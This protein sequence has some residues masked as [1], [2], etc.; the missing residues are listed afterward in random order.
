MFVLFFS[1]TFFGQPLES[2]KDIIDYDEEYEIVESNLDELDSTDL[3]HFWIDNEVEQ[4]YGFIASNYS[5]LWIKFLSIIPN[6]DQPKQYFV[7]GKSMVSDNVCEFQGLIEIK[8]SYNVKT[9]EFP[10]RKTGILAGE[11]VFYEDAES[12]HSGIFRGRFVTYWY[13]DE[14]GNFKYNDLLSGAAFY[15]NNQFAGI[16]TKYSSDKPIPANWGDSRIPNSGD[17]DVGTSE[18]GVNRKYRENGWDSFIKAWGGGF[19][20]EERENAREAEKAQWWNEK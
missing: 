7:Y 18:F 10:I 4:R 6:S 19:S 1:I 14:A 11:Y 15:N 16:W 20:K 13:K 5:R 12:G 3:N 2:Y 8:E 9:V 17:L